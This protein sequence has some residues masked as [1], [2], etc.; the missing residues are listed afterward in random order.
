[1]GIVVF[2]NHS[3]GHTKMKEIKEKSSLVI[4]SVDKAMRVFE[5]V[6][7]SEKDAR[8]VDISK[9]LGINKAT[10]YRVLRTFVEIGYI[11]QNTD[12]DRY[13]AT[14]KVMALGNHVMNKMEIR[15]LASG[16]IK[17][18]CEI[19][20]KSVHFSVNDNNKAVIIEKVEA[21]GSNKVSFHIGRSSELYSTGTGKVFLANMPL[22]ELQSYL[23]SITL[24]AHTPMTIVDPTLLKRNLDE[25]QKSGFAIDRQENNVGISCVA[26]PVID[27]SGKVVAAVAVTGPS[28][29]VEHDIPKLSQLILEYCSQISFK[30]GYGR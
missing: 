29:Q 28:S 22:N 2:S 1:M 16:I 24:K 17:E 26:G 10:V 30:L 25:I 14:M 7:R 12:T 6:C 9:S 4:Q 23:T 11:E 5:F 8:I 15:T 19:S 27:Y 21:L 13:R 20:G 18:L 3:L